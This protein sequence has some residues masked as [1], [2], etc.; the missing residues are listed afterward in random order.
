L[1][2]AEPSAIAAFLNEQRHSPLDLS[3]R[4]LAAQE[5]I[6]SFERNGPGSGHGSWP[7]G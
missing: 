2:R 5:S 7:L 1:N 6:S 3:G 4:N